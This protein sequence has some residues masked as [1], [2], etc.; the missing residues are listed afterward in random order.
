MSTSRG[1]ARIA[2]MY[3]RV[4]SESQLEG[5]GYVLQGQEQGW[6]VY[7]KE[8]GIEH[9]ETF[10]TAAGRQRSS[11]Y[12]RRKNPAPALPNPVLAQQSY[13][14]TRSQP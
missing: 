7:V 4:G 5:S 9:D 3:C 11:L 13:K 10:K 12:R 1:T 6:R 14:R 2:M 8:P